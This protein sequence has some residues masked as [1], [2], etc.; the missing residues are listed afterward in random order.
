[1][2]IL[3]SRRLRVRI[4]G[5]VVAL[6]VPV[7]GVTLVHLA[8]SPAP[9][10]PGAEAENPAQPEEWMWAQRAN[11]DGSIP[12]AAYQEALAQTEVLDG[13]TARVDRS[14]WGASWRLLGPA[15]IGGRLIDV[16]VHPTTPGTVYVAAGTGGVWKSTDG[17]ATMTSVWPDYLPQS[18]GAL[19]IAPDGTLFAGTGEPDHGG[20]GSYYGTGLY[21]STNGGRTWTSLGLKNTGAIGRIRIDPTD[22]RRIFVAAQGRLFDTGGDRGLFLSVNGGKTWRKVLDGP[23]DSTGAID[24]AINPADPDVLLAALW[25]KLRFP[26]ARQYGGPGSGLHRSADGGRTWTRVGDPL[27][28]SETQPGRIG[29]AFATST[30]GRAYAITNDLVGNL[31]GFFVSDDAGATWTRPVSGE[32]ALDAADG[33]FA[34]WF[35]RLWVDPADAAHVFSAGVPLMESLDGGLTWAPSSG[36]HVDQHAMAWDP[37]NADRVYVGNDGGLYWSDQN[38]NVTGT[39]TAATVQPYMQFYAMDVA[40][41][42]VSRVSGGT[43][44]NGSLRS[45]GGPDWNQHR[46]GDGMMNRINPVD[47]NNVYAC[48]QNGGCARSDDGGNTMTAIRARF[49]GTRFNWVS[50]LELAAGSPDTVYFGSNILNRSD[51][52]GNTWRAVS[53]DLTGGPTPRNSTSYGTITAIGIA[54]TDKETVYVGTDDGRLWVTRDGGG[55]WTQLT[56]PD[57]PDRWVTRVTVD[58]ADADTAWVTYSGFKWESETQPHVLMTTDGGAAWRDISGRLPQ[59]PVNDVIRHPRHAGWLY[60]G[61]DMGVFFSPN[62]G[63]TWLRVGRGLPRVPVTDIH[64]HA[65]TS[66]IFAATFGRSI[67]SAKVPG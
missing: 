39:W 37:H 3:R 35:G 7:G 54:P 63:R 64:L 62:L 41:Q 14:L 33:G 20:G 23:N 11:P 36:M 34:W 50:P 65:A 47:L 59:A 48:S 4:A 19:A 26:D 17:G 67:W 21:R 58:P 22:P 66:T 56:D 18:M 43:Q 15:N 38:G 13:E 9:A 42:D 57:L 24:V 29:V 8:G 6:F 1:M 51:D 25:D 53:P 12:A 5:V 49:T 40:A 60:V 46:G 61:T 27:P 44:D 55:A 30:P 31:T 45:W 2:G 10:G 28:A 32:P 52:R 16:V